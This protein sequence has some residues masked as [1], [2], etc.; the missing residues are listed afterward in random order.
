MVKQ[1]RS[2]CFITHSSVRIV[3]IISKI[4]ILQVPSTIR[5]RKQ[6]LGTTPEDFSPC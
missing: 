1:G 5:Q 6:S 4:M 3:K 2:A